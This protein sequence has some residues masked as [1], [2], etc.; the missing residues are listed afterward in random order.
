MNALGLIE[1]QLQRMKSRSVF[2]AAPDQ[3]GGSAPKTLATYALLDGAVQ[4]IFEASLVK[5]EPGQ[6]ITADRKGAEAA[7]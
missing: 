4:S 2:V 6:R 5:R 1:Q 7:A 3:S